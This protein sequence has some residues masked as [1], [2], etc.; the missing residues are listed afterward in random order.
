MVSASGCYWYL[1]NILKD[2][3]SEMKANTHFDYIIIGNGLAGLQL[4]LKI[5]SDDFFSE[6]QIALIDPSDKTKND[7]IWSFWETEPSQWD[8]LPHKT[9]KNTRIVTSRK[10]I[11]LSLFPYSYKSI[12][13]IDF[14]NYAKTE[15]KQHGNIH[16]IIDEVVSTFES[17]TVQIVAK[18]GIYT[19]K[20][21]FDSRLPDTFQQP[22]NSISLHQHFKGIVIKTETDVFDEHTFTMMDYRLKDGEQTTFTY[23]LP[24]SKTEA[25]V[26]FTYFT[27]ALVPETRYNEF[28]KTYIKDYL[29]IE[30][31]SIEAS[32]MG[33]IPMTTFPF[34]NYNTAKITK[35][36]TGGGWVKPSTGYSFKHTE[37]KVA[38]IVSNIKA[39]KPP[40]QNLFK[41]KY[42]FYDKV[43]LKVLKD[44]NHKGEEIF[45]Q[46][47]GKNSTTTMFK[48]LDEESHF[49]EELGIMW[50][51]ISW[52]FV[53]A[54]FK[55][56]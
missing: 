13:A 42:K 1:L 31:Y 23:V 35:I 45:R 26:E 56:L 8:N 34:D 24:F 32:E 20:H 2:K 39:G 53:K 50:S 54:F 52:R 48:F 40:S 15:L 46:F 18:Q 29:N 9:W 33:N 22:N 19:A 21:V 10:T 6:Q 14:Y 38:K 27:E 7:K 16:F 28:I 3:P 30:N 12:R 4:A 49:F 43:F 17:D 47:Y 44:N 55:T 36:G 37:K 51:L 25:L 11:D 5:A 41:K